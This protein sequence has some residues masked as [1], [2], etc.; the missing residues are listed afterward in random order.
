MS[1]Q[2]QIQPATGYLARIR[3]GQRP[4]P[5][6]G[7]CPQRDEY[8]D[9]HWAGPGGDHDDVDVHTRRLALLRDAVLVSGS[10]VAGAIAGG[11]V[12]MLFPDDAGHGEHR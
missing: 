9:E 1:A 7:T 11:L 5:W 4:A 6:V 2:A 8:P 10:V 12:W 3:G